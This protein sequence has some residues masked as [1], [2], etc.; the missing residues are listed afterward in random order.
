MMRLERQ[1]VH[2]HVGHCI[3][4]VLL[5]LPPAPPPF[6]QSCLRTLKCAS[7]N[8]LQEVVIQLPPTCPLTDLVGLLLPRAA[9]HIYHELMMRLHDN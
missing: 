7:C 5:L 6:L 9:P 4:Y 3:T 1:P 2:I 8:N